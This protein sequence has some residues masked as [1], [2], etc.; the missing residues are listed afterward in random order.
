MNKL[1]LG[2]TGLLALASGAVQAQTIT[3]N[4]PGADD[5]LTS[6]LR[7]ASLS[8]SINADEETDKAPQDYV[9]AARADYRRLLTALYAA[10]YYSPVISIQVNGSEAAGIPPLDSPQVIDTVTLNVQPGPLFTFGRADITPVAPGTELPEGYAV[11]ADAKADVIRQ[12]AS[13]ARTRWQELGYAKVQV[14]DQQIIAQHSDNLLAA[15]VTLDTGPQL[16]FG[17]LI[18]T[19][20]ADVRTAAIQRIAGLPTGEV[21][22][23]DALTAAANRLRRTGAFD[24]VALTE[25]DDIAAGD[26]LPITATIAESLPRRIGFGLELSSVEG[27]RVSTFWIHRNAFGGAENFRIDGEVAGIG[28]TTGGTDYT[29]STALKVP[30][31]YGP[32]TDFTFTT[33][34]SR[35]DEPEFL[36]DKFSTE[37]LVTRLITEDLEIEGGLGLLLAQ[38]ETN[39]GDRDYLLLTAPLAATYD[40]RNSETNATSGYYIKASATPFLALDGGESGARGFLDTRGYVSFGTDDRFTIAARAQLGTVIGPDIDQAPQDFLFYSGGTSTV[41]GQGYQ[42]LG[43]PQIVD[44]ETVTVGG[45]SFAGAQIEARVGITEAISAVGFYDYGYVGA[46]SAPFQDGADQSGVGIGIRYDTGIGPIRLDIGTPA[47]GDDQFKSVEVYIGIG[48]AF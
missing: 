35:E 27:V 9:A 24:S 15:D 31:I 30:A 40:K 8:V 2:A 18:V 7:D 5:D 37:A 3:L 39:F 6:L 33:A 11:G 32:Q 4:A 42:S 36:I 21:Y 1:V 48:Q 12:A 47:S 10:G 34:I 13:V 16:T 17:P 20:N 23:P 44:G 22:S 43:V 14:A 19:G 45:K 41:R 25:A 38:E 29:L 46:D 28:G 26:T